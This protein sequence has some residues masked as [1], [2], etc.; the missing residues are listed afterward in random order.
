MDMLVGLIQIVCIVG[1]LCGLYLSVTCG[2][3]DKLRERRSRITP[4]HTAFD[5][6]AVNALK[7]R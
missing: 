1:L 7:L 6:L 5:P 4:V 3:P 2:E